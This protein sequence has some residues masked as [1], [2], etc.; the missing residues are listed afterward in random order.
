[1]ALADRGKAQDACDEIA[2]K[3]SA[4]HPHL[5]SKVFVTDMADGLFPVKADAG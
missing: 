1:M 4:L 3:F 2:W 5:P